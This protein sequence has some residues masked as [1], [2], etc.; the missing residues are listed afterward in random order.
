MGINSRSKGNKNERVAAALVTKWT[1]RKFERTPSSGGLQ[2]NASFSKGDIVCTVD[3]HYCPFCFEVKA[4]RDIDFSHL[5]V[6][7]IKNIKIAEFWAQACRDALSCEKI[8]ILMMRYDRLPKEFFFIAIPQ[9][10]A[11][12]LGLKST[13]TIRIEYTG[14]SQ[15]MDICILSSNEFFSLP[16]KQVRKLAKLQLKD[17]KR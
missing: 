7:G 4:H 11:N 6:P 3:K 14:A 1:K 17:G 8:P 2:W 9:Y 16:Y 5:L 10:F 13:K 12:T 15:A